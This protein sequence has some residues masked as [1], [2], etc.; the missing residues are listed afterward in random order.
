MN[1]EGAEPFPYSDHG[2]KYLLSLCWSVQLLYKELEL[3]DG[4]VCGFLVLFVCFLCLVIQ[5][6]CQPHLAIKFSCMFG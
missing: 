5:N 4:G 2:R 3:E 6:N 1:F